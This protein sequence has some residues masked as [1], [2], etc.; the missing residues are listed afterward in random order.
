MKKIFL[1][2]GLVSLFTM[3]SLAQNKN[4]SIQKVKDSDSTTVFVKSNPNDKNLFL[5]VK[6]GEQITV[7]IDGKK[8]D[9]EIIDL[10]DQD[11]IASVA[12]LNGETAMKKYNEPNVI[13]IITKKWK[14][15]WAQQRIEKGT[16][17]PIVIVDGK[18][19]SKEEFK[20]FP[21]ESVESI[22]VL[23]DDESKKKYK[24]E[25]GVILI[26]TKAAGKEEKKQKK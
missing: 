18:Q 4:I 6:D 24:T 5:K 17:D 22:N 13:L 26:T 7:I 20:T 11:K 12:V 19:I 3:A 25:V 2:I 15:E 16:E 10:L 23:K 1:V 14:K 8:Y 9:S 21:H